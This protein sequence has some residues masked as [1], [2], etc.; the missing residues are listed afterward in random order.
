MENTKRYTVFSMSTLKRQVALL[1]DDME[2]PEII[3]PPN[4]PRLSLDG[5]RGI[6]TG[7]FENAPYAKLLTQSEAEELVT[8][9]E[10]SSPK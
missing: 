1:K 10:W 4:N 5:T 9:P 8:T 6:V 2:L 3:S 7:I